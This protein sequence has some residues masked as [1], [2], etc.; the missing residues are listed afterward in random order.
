MRISVCV[1]VACLNAA[2][3]DAAAQAPDGYRLYQAATFELRIP[4]NAVVRQLPAN[5]SGMVTRYAISGPGSSYL[6]SIA[7]YRL[8]PA[9]ASRQ[10]ARLAF[11]SDSVQSDENDWGVP[12]AVRRD[13]VGA[14]E[15]WG[16]EP[17]C[18]DCTSYRV[19]L[20]RGEMLLSFEYVYSENQRLVPRQRAVY[21]RIL[22][23]FRWRGA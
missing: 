3:Q 15:A 14:L 11:H 18:G 9:M 22:A 5:D 13:T 1:L 23:S 8:T 17:T 4:R 12:G 10:A 2:S 20:S 6:L 21:R 19:Y 16:F 7:Q